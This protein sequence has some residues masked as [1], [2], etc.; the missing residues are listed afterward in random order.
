MGKY[1]QTYDILNISKQILLAWN[2]NPLKEVG[3]RLKYR[4]ARTR[5]MQEFEFVS[6]YLR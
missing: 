1:T 6:K 3:R 2:A 5:S 4:H